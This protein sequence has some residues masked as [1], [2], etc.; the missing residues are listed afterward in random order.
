VLIK[1]TFVPYNQYTE[2]YPPSLRG[3]EFPNP[4]LHVGK[5]TDQ[6]AWWYLKHAVQL[7]VVNVV[8]EALHVPAEQ[9]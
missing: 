8:G 5:G 6:R 1:K 9:D 7:S 4:R 3:I 2:G